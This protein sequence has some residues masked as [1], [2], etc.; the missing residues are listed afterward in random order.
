MKKTTGKTSRPH[1]SHDA[2]E[3]LSALSTISE[4]AR[5]WRRVQT[6][7]LIAATLG[8]VEIN[9]LS[10]L[11]FEPMVEDV[12]KKYIVRADRI[13]FC[14]EGEHLDGEPPNEPNQDGD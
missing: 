10:D 11:E 13:L 9:T 3:I 8:A 14:A 1:I 4:D 2:A 12:I 6:C 5:R 7:A